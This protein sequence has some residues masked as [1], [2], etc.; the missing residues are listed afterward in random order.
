VKTRVSSE[1]QTIFFAGIGG[2]G[3]SA[4]ARH[5]HAHGK[6]VMGYDRTSTELTRTLESSGMTIWY[7]IEPANWPI[8]EIDL[9]VYT[10]ALPADH[11]VL[12]PFTAAGVPMKKR[13][14]VL[15]MISKD[16]RT[17]AVAGTHGKTSTTSLLTHILRTGGVDC[18]AFLGGIAS[19]LGSNFAQGNSEWVVVEADEY[20]RSFLHLL[21]ECAAIMSMD[22]D[23]LD[24][25]GS[26]NQMHANGYGLFFER[27]KKE[28]NLFYNTSIEEELGTA[29]FE[30][31][32]PDGL[33]V[34]SFGTENGIYQSHHIRVEEG[35]MVFDLKSPVESIENLRLSFPGRHN[36]E[37]ATAAI[38]LAQY[39]GVDGASIRK[40]LATFKGIRRRFERLIERPDLVYIDDYAHHPTELTAA[41]QAARIFYPNRQLLGVFQPHLFS[42]TQ[43]FAPGFAKALSLLDEVILLDIYPARE[44]PIP[45]VTSDMVFTQIHGTI[46]HRM[47]RDEIMEY[48]AEKA[49]VVV[50]TLVARNI[51]L[52]RHEVVILFDL[53]R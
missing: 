42:R 2:I 21:P 14:E 8:E 40:A 5:Y 18:T 11:P 9:V 26:V 37:N 50:M 6:R 25:Y 19:N 49:L 13:A 3:M 28:G 48:L 51:D 39:A 44:E 52:V 33:Q 12:Q 31:L 22:A 23:H 38:A 53:I 29:A 32:I 27:I 46:K 45:G 10:A 30:S 36:V 47:K 4:I 17:L 1:L 41:I 34:K 43:D 15:G 20:D 16:F 35:Y 7:E 24:I